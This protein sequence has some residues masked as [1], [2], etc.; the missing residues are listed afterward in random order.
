MHS[1][2]LQDI[3]QWDVASWGKALPLWQQQLDRLR[4][5]T[6]LA[7]GEREGG[8]SLWLALQG[9]QV[10]CSDLN[11]FPDETAKMHERY[12]VQDRISYQRQDALDLT[13]DDGHYDLVIFKSVIGSLSTK[14][15][16][17]RAISE[18]HR[19]LKPGGVL[20]FAENMRSTYL[21]AYLRRRYIRWASY[22]RYLHW[23]QDRD[24]FEPFYKL[25]LR[26]YGLLAALGRSPWQR[27]ALSSLDRFL[28]PITPSTWHYI[29][30]GT[31]V[32]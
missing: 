21:H 31:A 24:L 14:E 27:R 17:L 10:V 16:Q 5:Q 19:V 7:I 30:Y 18:M 28:C 12:Q 13:V 25:D 32:K 6:A 9:I 23:Q 8:L 11:P 20:L 26:S 3:L 4:P 29:M 15:R 2:Q 1:G 22:W